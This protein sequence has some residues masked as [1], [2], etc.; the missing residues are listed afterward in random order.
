MTAV[1]QPVPVDEPDPA[2]TAR[3]AAIERTGSGNLVYLWQPRNACFWVY[4]FGVAYGLWVLYGQINAAIRLYAPALTASAIIFAVYGML[5]W[6][7]TV[8]IDRYSRQPLR[9]VI[10][11]F[12]WGGVAAAWGIALSGN[13]ALLS[14][15]Q[16]LFGQAF[17]VAWG[18][19]LTAPLFEELGKGAGVL[20]LVFLAPRVVRTAYDGFILGAFVGLGFEILEDI[21]YGYNSANEQFGSDQLGTSLS[22]VGMRLLTGFS[23]H[24]LY[25]AL[26]GAGIVYL[27]GTVAQRRRAG[28]GTML[29][30]VAMLLHGVWDANAGISG[31]NGALLLP[32]LIGE[33]LISLAVVIGLFHY[34]VRPER[35]AMRAVMAPEAEQGVITTEELDALSGG[36]KQRR[37]YRK[38]ANSRA[39]SRVRRH[40]LEAAHDLADQIAASAGAET[41][42]VRF[43]RAELVRL[44]SA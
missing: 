44:E 39:E 36:W 10:A 13:S 34:T 19:G 7:F 41:D 1:S 14:I 9:L 29:I 37:A 23:S 30:V 18:A 38:A 27:L 28:F 8:R 12:V 22:T 11:A 5:F 4:V 3:E 20:L 31:G 2:I 16:K 42:R 43:A 25:S 24:I 21:S 15:Y 40:R 32:L 17:Q 6:W 33:I 35:A 26:V